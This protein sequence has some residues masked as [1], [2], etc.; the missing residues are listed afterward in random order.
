MTKTVKKVY[1]LIHSKTVTPLNQ[2]YL[3]KFDGGA[4]PNPGK[5]GSGAVLFSPNGSKIWEVGQFMPH[6]TNNQAEYTGLF[7]GLKLCKRLGIAD[8]KIEGDSMLVIKQICGLW[9]V[10]ADGI[11]DLSQQ[12]NTLLRDFNYVVARHVYREDN[13]EADAI[14]NELQAT[15]TNFERQL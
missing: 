4:V 7:I 2:C 11:K 9:A 10:K 3:L 8:L 1:N 6:G 13:T 5:C 12:V 15:Q 14:T